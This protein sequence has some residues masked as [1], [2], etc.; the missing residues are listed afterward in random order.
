MQSSPQSSPK[1]QAILFCAVCA[2]G[3][4]AGV[5][6]H[7]VD[8]ALY[9]GL[10]Q[11][12]QFS[13]VGRLNIT[14]DSGSIQCSG[15]LLNDQWILTAAH[16]VDDSFNSITFAGAEGFGAVEEVVINP[17]WVRNDFFAGGDLAL[18]R[19]SNPVQSAN[20]AQIYGGTDEIGE[21]GTI[22]GYGRTGTG[23]TGHFGTS[24]AF[25]AGHNTI[26]VLGTARGWSERIL[27]TDFDSPLNANESN[28]GD[29]EPLDLEY[30]IAPGD[31]GGAMFVLTE[32]G[33]QIAGVSSFINSTDGTPNGDYGDSNGFTRVSAY[34]DWINSVVPTPGSM[35][36]LAMGLG[37]G[38]RRRRMS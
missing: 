17:D 1:I 2:A 35:T 27:L 10:A 32:A 8:D 29:S 24:A 30:S 11:Q 28:Y 19:L 15:T 23:L 9:R 22:V 33:W 5:I 34:Q 31:S 16:C 18:L 36:M 6:R 3:A 4:H 12:D 37:L 20:Q 14:S 25:R 7:D 38:A 21:V 13:S 26:D